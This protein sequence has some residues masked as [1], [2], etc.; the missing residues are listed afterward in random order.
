MLRAKREISERESVRVK[1]VARTS[2]LGSGSRVVWRFCA[3]A[4]GMM[5][6][7]V[8]DGKDEQLIEKYKKNVVIDFLLFFVFL[9]RRSS[10]L[11]VFETRYK[12]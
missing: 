4:R 12:F 6:D 5:R 1:S 3:S 10:L 9:K 8:R 2:L 7:A 11:I